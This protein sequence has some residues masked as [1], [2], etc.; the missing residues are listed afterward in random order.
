VTLEDI[1]AVLDEA[2]AL[3]FPVTADTRGR[4]RVELLEDHMLASAV[5]NGKLVEARHWLRMLRASLA[6]SWEKL[7]GWEIAM[8]GKPRA[9]WTAA[10]IQRAKIKVAP[11]QYDAGREAK[12]LAESIDDQIARLERDERICSRAYSMLSGS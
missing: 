5:V 8:A 4:A 1:R 10:D 12:R 2:L 11:A 3:R 9:R 7:A 6:D